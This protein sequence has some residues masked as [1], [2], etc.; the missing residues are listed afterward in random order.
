MSLDIIGG[1][2]LVSPINRLQNALSFNFYANTEMYDRRADSVDKSTGQIVDG[3]KLGE[4][5]QAFGV[6][7]ERLEESLKTEGITNQTNDNKNTGDNTE[8]K[9]KGDFTI[10]SE[11]ITGATGTTQKIIINA[12]AA[13]TENPVRVI[14][15]KQYENK[16]SEIINSLGSETSF[17]E[18]VT[19][20]IEDWIQNDIKISK[21]E[22]DNEDLEL[23]IVNFENQLAS[24][25]NSPNIPQLTRKLNV[26]KE[27]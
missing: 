2:S 17:I 15:T 22:T 14:I 7:T 11:S 25:T 20:D 12:P 18:N 19:V 21:L 23:E 27:K 6:D 1:Q 26:I 8:T 5:K 4:L 10:N 13:T 16:F 9:S 3:V 24:N